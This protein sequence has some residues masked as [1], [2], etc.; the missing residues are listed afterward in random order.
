MGGDK[1]DER[2]AARFPVRPPQ[3]LA[4]ADEVIE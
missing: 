1:Q 4:R 3:L 2:R